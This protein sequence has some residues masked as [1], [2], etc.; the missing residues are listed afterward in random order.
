MKKLFKKEKNSFPVTVETIEVGLMTAEQEK[1]LVEFLK[2]MYKPKNKFL[3]L[4]WGTIMSIVVKVVDNFI[5]ELI[6][7]GAREKIKPILDEL[8]Y[9]I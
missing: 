7:E 8:F 3:N 2:V 1:K 9:S 5:L 6:P 4:F